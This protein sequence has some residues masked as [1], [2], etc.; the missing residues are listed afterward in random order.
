MPPRHYEDSKN[1]QGV[2][3]LVATRAA[4]QVSPQ[5]PRTASITAEWKTAGREAT[6]RS[7]AIGTVFSKAQLS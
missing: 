6:I 3:P 4:G 7:R 2:S 5:V 1:L